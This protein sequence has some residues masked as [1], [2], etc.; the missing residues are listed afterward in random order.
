MAEQA[1]A[2]SVVHSTYPYYRAHAQSLDQ[3]ATDSSAVCG[4]WLMVHTA[5]LGLCVTISK[6]TSS[7]G[8]LTA[9]FNLHGLKALKA[10]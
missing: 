4:T 5:R 9:F 6:V 1:L 10:S 3:L 2:H 8:I 7:L